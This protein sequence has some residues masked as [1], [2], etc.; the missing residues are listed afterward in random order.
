LGVEKII[1]EVDV[2]SLKAASHCARAASVHADDQHG[3]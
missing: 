3:T 2:E 1:A